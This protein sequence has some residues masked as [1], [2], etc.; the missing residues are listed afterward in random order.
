LEEEVCRHERRTTTLA[1][2]TPR[3]EPAAETNVCRC[4]LGQQNVQRR[5]FKKVGGTLMLI[6]RNHE[7]P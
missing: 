4:F 2:K 5:S 7:E 1:E 3:R 6:I